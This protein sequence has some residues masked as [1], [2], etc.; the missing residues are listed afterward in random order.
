[1]I[2]LTAQKIRDDDPITILYSYVLIRHEIKPKWRYLTRFRLASWQRF[3][4]STIRIAYHSQSLIGSSNTIEA[5]TSSLYFLAVFEVLSVWI[6]EIN[7]PNNR[8]DIKFLAI[9]I[10]FKMLIVRIFQTKLYSFIVGDFR[11][12]LL[13]YI[14]P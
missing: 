12:M 13:E 3:K 14:V 5:K 6:S 2:R 11:L 8:M 4:T 7:D 9:C 1:M 10:Y